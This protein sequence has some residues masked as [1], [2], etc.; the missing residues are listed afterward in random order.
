LYSISRKSFLAFKF[1]TFLGKKGH[2]A[3][4]KKCQSNA[5]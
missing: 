4:N 3:E 5:T 2:S 1:Y